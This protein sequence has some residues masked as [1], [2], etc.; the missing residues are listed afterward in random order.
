MFFLFFLKKDFEPVCRNSMCRGFSLWVGSFPVKQ[1]T[2]N[3]DG[4]ARRHDV[5]LEHVVGLH[6]NTETR[7]ATP[8]QVPPIWLVAYVHDL[9]KFS[10]YDSKT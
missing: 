9:R 4:V 10:H 6:Y 2:E 8:L 5:N 7:Q 1:M 3:S